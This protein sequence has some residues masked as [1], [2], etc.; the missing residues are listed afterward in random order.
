MRRSA[1][2]R[3]PCQLDPIDAS[4]VQLW[5]GSLPERVRRMVR[6]LVVELIRV[7]LGSDDPRRH[8]VDLVAQQLGR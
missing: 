1:A 7:R 4:L 5:Y 3:V 6:R 8:A 2:R